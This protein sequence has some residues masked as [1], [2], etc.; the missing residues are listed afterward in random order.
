MILGGELFAFQAKHMKP[1]FNERQRVEMG[2]ILPEQLALAR[3]LF[4]NGTFAAV[5]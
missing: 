3:S 5:S 2:F 4:Q 1:A